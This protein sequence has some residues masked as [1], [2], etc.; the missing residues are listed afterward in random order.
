MSP[1]ASSYQSFLPLCRLSLHSVVSF[2]MRE[3]FNLML[4]CLSLLTLLPE[5]LEVLGYADV[6]GVLKIQVLN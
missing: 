4:F 1:L 3:F 6:T 2:A 5:L